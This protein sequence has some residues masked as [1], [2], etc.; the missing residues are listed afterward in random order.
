[1]DQL[2]GLIFDMFVAGM[3]TTSSTL[4]TAIY[5]MTQHPHVQRQVQQELDEVV[6]RE[7]LPSFSDMER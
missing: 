2:A 7:R 3:E 1:M 5:L 6:G 4:T